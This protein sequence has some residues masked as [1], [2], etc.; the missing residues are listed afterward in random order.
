MSS[1]FF[2]QAE[3]YFVV[4]LLEA[5]D[6]SLFEIHAYSDVIQPDAV[7]ERLRKS[8]DVWR[9]VQAFSDERLAAQIREDEIDGGY[10]ATALGHGIVTEGDT[11]EELRIMVKDAVHCYFGDGV[12]GP[13]PKII[14]LH[15]VHDEALAV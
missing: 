11:I 4:P 14:R 15:F 7:T 3:C 9:D 5:H 12:P 1:N 10:V 8:V 2:G 13:M 6:H